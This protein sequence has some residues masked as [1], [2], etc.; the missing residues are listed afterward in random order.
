M[1][2]RSNEGNGNGTVYFT[3]F[4]RGFCYRSKMIKTDIYYFLLTIIYPDLR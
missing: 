2:F 3:E 1:K 4:G